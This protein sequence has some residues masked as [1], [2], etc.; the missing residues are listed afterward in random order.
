MPITMI[1]T[2]TTAPAISLGS[3]KLRCISPSPRLDVREGR[4]L[5]FRSFLDSGGAL[6]VV[7]VE[8]TGFRKLVRIAHRTELLERSA[9][10]IQVDEHGIWMCQ[11]L[12]IP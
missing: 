10:L 3:V 8:R 12:I 7:S 2:I 9:C 11:R 1:R 5:W 4:G 6:Y